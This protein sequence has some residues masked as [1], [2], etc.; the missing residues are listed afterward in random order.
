MEATKV[1]AARRETGLTE[2]EAQRR[3]RAE[4]FNDLPRQAKRGPWRILVEVLREPML[5]LL[6]AGGLVYLLIGDLYEALLLIAFANISVLITFVQESR[7]ER[8]L[9]ALKDLTSPRALVIRDGLK[10]RIP[11]REVARGDLVILSEGDRVPADCVILE[12]SNLAADES[13]LTG[14][15]VPVGKSADATG[16]A[17]TNARPGGDGQSVAFSGALIVRGQGLARVFATGGGTAIGL[18]GRSLGELHF[19]PP[20]LQVEMRQVVRIFG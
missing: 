16:K 4:G 2:E 18:I 1:T 14:E 20:R 8:V 17:P 10:R 3:L 11:G 5:L 12:A 9:D 15:A 19:E 6:L 7:T 13:L